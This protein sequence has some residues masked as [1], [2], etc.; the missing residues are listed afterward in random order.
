V[1][2]LWCAVD[3]R[4]AP[5]LA[6]GARGTS[7][8]RWQTEWGVGNCEGRL[9]PVPGP[10]SKILCERRVVKYI[11]IIS[12]REVFDWPIF[13][14]GTVSNAQRARSGYPGFGCDR[15]TTRACTHTAHLQEKRCAM[16]DKARCV[17]SH[18]WANG[19]DGEA[20]DALCEQ[21]P[22]ERHTHAAW[23]ASEGETR[24]LE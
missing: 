18:A 15:C 3:D 20:R 8:G 21:L 4:K 2:F 19:R 12:L 11:Y 13:L 6:R 9:C 5:T 10:T 14:N 17:T 16:A 1:I 23:R 24:E 22:S 7:L